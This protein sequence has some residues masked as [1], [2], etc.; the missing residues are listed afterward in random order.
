MHKL[1]LAYLVLRVA[2]LL[3]R[4][5]LGTA[6][7]ATWQAFWFWVEMA[8]FVVPLAAAGFRERAPQPASCSSAPCC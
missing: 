8:C 5:A 7:A 1:L 6:F 2:D 3:L 4:G